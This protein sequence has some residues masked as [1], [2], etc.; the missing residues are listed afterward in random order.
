MRKPWSREGPGR[1]DHYW[2]TRFQVVGS[3]LVR[4]DSYCYEDS[5]YEVPNAGT[6]EQA[7]VL[8]G[9]EPIEP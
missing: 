8:S 7:T 3:A 1:G 9:L 6:P 4:F 2:L 5:T